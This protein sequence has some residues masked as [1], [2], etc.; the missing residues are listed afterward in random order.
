[1]TDDWYNKDAGVDHTTN[2]T[3]VPAMDPWLADNG[4][5]LGATRLTLKQRDQVKVGDIAI[6]DWNLNGQGDHTMI[7]SKIVPGA[8]ADGANAIKLVGHNLNYDFRDFDA[9]ITTDHPG[10]TAW[11][12]SL[13]A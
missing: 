13:D 1:M 4:A 9:T 12:H 8:G 10:A 7:V 6:F 11:F 2:W 5:T 3:Y